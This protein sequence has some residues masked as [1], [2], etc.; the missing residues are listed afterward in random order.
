MVINLQSASI[1]FVDA[2]VG[3]GYSYST[4]ASDYSI[5]DLESANQ[6]HVFIRKVS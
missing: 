1:I 5:T 6:S 3:S 2:P 4:N